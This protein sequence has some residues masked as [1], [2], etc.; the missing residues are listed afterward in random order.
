MGYQDI[1]M[2]G[3]I[4]PYFTG[5]GRVVHECP[6]KKTWCA[7]RAIKC[8]AFNRNG[9]IVQIVKASAVIE[10]C[11]RCGVVAQIMIAGDVDDVIELILLAQ[12]GFKILYFFRP[13][14]I[15]EVSGVNQYVVVFGRLIVLVPVSAVCV[16]DQECG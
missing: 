3:N 6:V 13:A 1:G 2:V 8:D 4:F 5:I 14:E 7:G 12:P 9:A 10:Q 16:A 11:N 15:G